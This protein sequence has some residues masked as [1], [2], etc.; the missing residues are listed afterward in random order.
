MKLGTNV[1]IYKVSP[2]KDGRERIITTLHLFA[3]LCP[4]E[5]ISIKNVSSL[6]LKNR[7]RYFHEAGYKNKVVSDNVQSTR[8]ITP[9]KNFREIMPL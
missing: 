3:E 2:D 6:Q 8:T 1:N 7:L 5:I 4:F 9:L